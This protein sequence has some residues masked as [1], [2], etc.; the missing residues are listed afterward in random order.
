MTISVKAC[1][2]I[3]NFSNIKFEWAYVLNMSMKFNGR[4]AQPAEWLELRLSHAEQY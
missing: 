1:F 4:E 3:V 2:K